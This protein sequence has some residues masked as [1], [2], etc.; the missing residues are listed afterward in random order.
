MLGPTMAQPMATR[1]AAAGLANFGIGRAAIVRPGAN[2]P[3]Q[4]AY[5]A[6][7]DLVLVSR[8]VQD[9]LRLNE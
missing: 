7:H 8:N 3:A 4:L 1:A 5:A 2:D 6:S 9:F